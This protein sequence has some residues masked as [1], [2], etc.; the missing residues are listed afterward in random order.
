MMNDD[1]EWERVKTPLYLRAVLL[2]NTEEWQGQIEK[3][4]P[5][6]SGWTGTMNNQSAEL[7]KNNDGRGI[8]KMQVLS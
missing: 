8:G 5:T 1:K 6:E 7:Q 2:H 4:K 3:E